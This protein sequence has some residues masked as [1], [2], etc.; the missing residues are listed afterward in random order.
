MPDFGG[1]VYVPRKGACQEVIT[2]HVVSKGLENEIQHLIPSAIGKPIT[3]TQTQMLYF[4]YKDLPKV[5]ELLDFDG[6]LGIYREA[7]IEA[8]VPEEFD[9]VYAI[10]EV[11]NDNEINE[12]TQMIAD[13]KFG[14]VWW[15]NLH[16]P[17]EK[18]RAL[19]RLH[20]PLNQRRNIDFGAS[21]AEADRAYAHVFNALSMD[22]LP[23]IANTLGVSLRWMLGLDK[24]AAI[25]RDRAAV[26]VLYDAY[27]LLAQR[28]RPVI[29]KILEGGASH[30]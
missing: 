12:L 14:D 29:I 2:K 3:S 20:Y 30:V 23:D 7:G 21:T 8:K 17:V 15:R 1:I 27:C 19:I 16:S 25:Y 9:Y 11:W 22:A 13:G 5:A 4:A 26:E 10:C 24:D 18:M 6:V 28:R